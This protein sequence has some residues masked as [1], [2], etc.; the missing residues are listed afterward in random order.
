MFPKDASVC[1]CESGERGK[2]ILLFAISYA[3]E[4]GAHTGALGY[5]LMG[6]KIG[7]ININHELYIMNCL[8]RGPPM[9][10]TTFFLFDFTDQTGKKKKL[11][12]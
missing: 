10:I 1:D 7:W 6:G 8:W 5:T 4:V 3:L 9:L 2:L 11:E 12:Y